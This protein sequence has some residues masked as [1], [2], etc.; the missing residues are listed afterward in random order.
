MNT[1]IY[2]CL[3]LVIMI[4]VFYTIRDYIELFQDSCDINDPKLRGPPGLPGVPGKDAQVL[5]SEEKRQ[6]IT[7]FMNDL[8]VE[9]G[10]YYVNEQKLGCVLP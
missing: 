4:V 1:I 8:R 7:Q 9:N 10:E 6:L 2:I 5:V 3:A